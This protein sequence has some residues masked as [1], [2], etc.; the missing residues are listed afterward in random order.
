MP[1][2][3]LVFLD[4]TPTQYFVLLAA[5]AMVS[6]Y[7]LDWALEHWGFGIFLNVMVLEIG[8][9]SGLFA[10]EKAGFYFW[11]EGL[12]VILTAIAGAFTMFIILASL[13]N[14]LLP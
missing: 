3:D 14:K 11:D 10:A 6:G 12:P 13:K 8:G 5:L 4:E 1:Y 9:L 2:L 7:A